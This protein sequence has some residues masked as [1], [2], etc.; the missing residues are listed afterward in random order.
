MDRLGS[1]YKLCLL[2]ELNGWI[3]DRMRE[4]TIMEEE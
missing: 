2:G 3:G 1:A 4:K